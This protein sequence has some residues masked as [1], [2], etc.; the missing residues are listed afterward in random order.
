[1]TRVLLALLLFAIASPAS[2]AEGG[3]SKQLYFQLGN[4]VL[5][6]TVLVVL[7]RRPVREFFER[8]R[9]EVGG[10]LDSAAQL[11]DQAEKRFLQ[12][13]QKLADLDAELETIRAESRDRAEQEREQV[14]ADAHATAERIKRDATAAVGQELRRARSE[15]RK[16]ASELAVELAE[17]MLR[18]QV[19]DSD[20]DR[21][22]DEFISEI[23]HAA[24]ARER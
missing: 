16:E 7:L 2:A 12:W 20:R 11:L 4:F 15:L 23:E 1:M 10:E 17:R 22:T 9:S 8:R 6:I 19:I 3:S 5:L 24:P 14:I 13:Q 18:E 21:L